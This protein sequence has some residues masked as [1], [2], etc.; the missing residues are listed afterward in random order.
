M[1]PTRLGDYSLPRREGEGKRAL[2]QVHVMYVTRT[3]GGPDREAL[4]NAE[5]SQRRVEVPGIDLQ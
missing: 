3:G 4:F 1:S 5:G 2:S